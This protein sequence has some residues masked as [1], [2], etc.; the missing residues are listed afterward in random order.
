MPYIRLAGA[1]AAAAILAAG[2]GA[3][4]G[5]QQRAESTPPTAPAGAAGH[6]VP[7]QLHFTAKTI[8]GQ[9]F[10]GASLFGKP[11]VLW[12]WTPWC[13]TCQGEAPMVGQAAAAHPG[14]TFVGVAGQ[15]QVAAMRAFVD[16]YP[17]KNFTQLADTT[18]AIWTKFG[19]TQQPAFAFIRPNGS[20]DVVKS[21]ISKADLNNRTAALTTP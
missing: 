17:V 12:F 8:E 1:L 15:D 14:V 9:E 18:G 21:A 19:V 6:T 3:H 2:C 5:A 4:P 16:K 13:P 7:E 11:A 10:Q 20:I